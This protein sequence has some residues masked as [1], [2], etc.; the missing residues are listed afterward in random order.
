MASSIER[1]NELFPLVVAGD[2]EARRL[3]IE[4]NMALVVVKADGLIKQIPNVAYL[5]DD[6]VSAG[7]VGLVEAVNKLPGGKIRVGA[8]NR[9]LGKIVT[10]RMLDLL[11]VERTIRVPRVSAEAARKPESVSWNARPID[12]P[13]VYNVL[14]E[15]LK[16]PTH[17]SIVDLHDVCEACCQTEAERECLRLRSEGHTLR[18][19]ANILA[20]PFST[21]KLL[22]SKLRRRILHAW[23]H[24][25]EEDPEEIRR[26]TAKAARHA[27]VQEN[28]RARNEACLRLR[29]EGRTYKEIADTL[30]LSIPTVR[31]VYRRLTAQETLTDKAPNDPPNLP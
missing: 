7:Y 15:T 10:R 21:T 20:L 11:P 5:R 13:V 25:G 8:F 2:S 24:P 31:G 29:R 12:V 28:K 3:L 17:F 27:E 14:P 16:A 4:E 6:L 9:L 1:N 18:E 30:N 22:F 26:K 19:I 23:D